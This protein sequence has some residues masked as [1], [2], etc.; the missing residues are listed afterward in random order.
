MNAH[1]TIPA[2]AA[3]AE[4]DLHRPVVYEQAKSALSES[5][6]EQNTK[7]VET[8]ISLIFTLQSGQ[9]EFYR[10]TQ[11]CILIGVLKRDVS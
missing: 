8:L 5:S 6:A 3:A 1:D 2:A 4:D 10:V 7:L 9:L 11:V